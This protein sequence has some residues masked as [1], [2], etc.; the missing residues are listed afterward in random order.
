VSL[1]KKRHRN[2]HF[3]DRIISSSHYCREEEHEV[4]KVRLRKC[5]L[6]GT[7]AVRNVRRHVMEKHLPRPF[8]FEQLLEPGMDNKRME[9]VLFLV[10]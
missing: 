8:K 9:L 2:P 6:D 3:R 10:G 1:N 4:K 5:P 7:A